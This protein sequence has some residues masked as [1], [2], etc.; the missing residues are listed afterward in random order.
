MKRCVNGVPEWM[1]YCLYSGK[2]PGL[3]GEAGMYSVITV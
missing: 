2:V 3:A 1:C